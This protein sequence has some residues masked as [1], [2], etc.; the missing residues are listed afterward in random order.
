MEKLFCEIENYLCDN[1]ITFSL[2]CCANSL[3]LSKEQKKIKE[4]RASYSSDFRD[5]KTALDNMD[6]GFAQTLFDL[7]DKSGM[8][9][10]EC[11]KRANVDKK[12]FSKMKCNQ[13]YRPSKI[14]AISFAIALKLDLENTERLLKT[15]GFSLSHSSKFDLII[16]YFIENKNYDIF[17]IN[18]AL[19]HFDQPLLGC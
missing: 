9:D 5:L 8:T 11:Y 4:E 6:K 3:P 19:L 2:I 18:K 7:I 16:K 12:T 10:V 13:H 1:L 14:T 15:A 17:I